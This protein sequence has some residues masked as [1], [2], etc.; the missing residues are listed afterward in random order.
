[1]AIFLDSKA[2]DFEARF[3]ALLAVPLMLA[4]AS[5][6]TLGSP[7]FAATPTHGAYAQT[8]Y[9]T[10][11]YSACLHSDEYWNGSTSWSAARSYSCS[12]SALLYAGSCDTHTEGSY[13]DGAYWEDW[14]DTSFTTSVSP[15]EKECVYLRLDIAPSGAHSV[16]AWASGPILWFQS[17]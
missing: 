6:V 4:G 11:G 17:C 3:V 14:A 9:S 1:M 5:T 12:Q 16:R 2:L 8:C 7:A 13:R 10:V 15:V